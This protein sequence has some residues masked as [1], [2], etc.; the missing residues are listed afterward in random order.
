M[1]IKKVKQHMSHMASDKIYLLKKKACGCR[2]LLVHWESIVDPQ[3]L[4]LSL[5]CC[6][7]YLWKINHVTLILVPKFIHFVRF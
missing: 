2:N 5:D 4:E 6:I 1:L 7:I 3:I